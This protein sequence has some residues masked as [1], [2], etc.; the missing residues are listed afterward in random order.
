VGLRR[1]DLASTLL[2]TLEADDENAAQRRSRVE[3]IAAHLRN[4]AEQLERTTAD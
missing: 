1:I 2:E 3:V 4:L